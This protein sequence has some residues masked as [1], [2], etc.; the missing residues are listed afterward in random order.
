[1]FWLA[2]LTWVSMPA[3]FILQIEWGFS[4]VWGW[5]GQP[6]QGEQ[7]DDS[8]HMRY[9]LRR[10]GCRAQVMF[11]PTWPC[12]G[13][14]I[15]LTIFDDVGFVRLEKEWVGSALV[16][17]T[18]YSICCTLYKVQCLVYSICCTLH[19]VPFIV[20]NVQCMVHNVHYTMF[21]V[22]AGIDHNGIAKTRECVLPCTA[23]CS[24]AQFAMHCSVQYS[25]VCSAVQCAV[26][27]SD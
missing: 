5:G 4:W 3:R 6:T 27:C 14:W 19:T 13:V 11:D 15:M 26:H 20:Y 17:S 1:M 24:T 25:T 23:V 21:S 18:V 16:Q 9:T 22:Q 10:K 2:Q 12:H 8:K 7:E